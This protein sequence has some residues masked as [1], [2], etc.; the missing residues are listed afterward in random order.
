MPLFRTP[1]FDNFVSLDLFSSYQEIAE[2]L[3]ESSRIN[4]FSKSPTIGFTAYN[5]VFMNS[6]EVTNDEILIFLFTS[7]DKDDNDRRVKHILNNRILDYQDW[8]GYHQ[9]PELFTIKFDLNDYNE[10][11]IDVSSFYKK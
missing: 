9:V 1:K 2:N 10:G 3:P 8:P 7:K 6:I 11:D 4:W 5:M